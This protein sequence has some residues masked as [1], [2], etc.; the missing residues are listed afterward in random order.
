[1][2]SDIQYKKDEQYDGREVTDREKIMNIL[3]SN[4][5]KFIRNDGQIDRCVK[6]YAKKGMVSL[7]FEKDR[8]TF[9][10]LREKEAKQ[11]T[12]KEVSDMLSRIPAF[13]DRV[14]ERLVFSMRF[15]GANHRVVVEGLDECQKTVNYFKGKDSK[16][17]CTNIPCFERIIYR[18]LYPSI[19]L[20]CRFNDGSLKYDFI[21]NPGASLRDINIAYSGIEGLEIDGGGNL[22]IKTPMGH[23]TDGSPKCYQKIDGRQVDIGAEFKLGRRTNGE[24]T[25]GFSINKKYDPN[26]PVII[27]PEIIYSSF[28]GGSGTD[29]GR[30]IA[31]DQDGCVYITGA[32]NSVDFPVRNGFDP[33]FNINYDAFVTK[34]SRIPTIV[35]SSYLGGRGL[36]GGNSIDMGSDIAI[37]R[38]GNAYIVG[39]TGSDNFPIYN[40]FDTQ[41]GGPNDAFITKISP[42]PAIVYSSYLGGNGFEFGEGIAVDQNGNAYVTGSTTSTDFPRANAFQNNLSGLQDAFITKINPVPDIVYSSY[43]GGSGLDAGYSVAADDF[44]NTYITG[45]TTSDDF[46]RVNAFQNTWG[47][48]FDAFITKISSTPTIVYSSYLGGSGEDTGLSVAVDKMGNAYVAGI[49]F[50]P[51]FPTVNAFD[52]SISGP[53]D[54]FIAKISPAHSIVYS[55]YVGGN[56]GDDCLGVVVDRIGNAYITGSTNST[57]FPI[58][59]A[60]QRELA[61]DYDAYVMK[62]EAVGNRPECILTTKVFDSLK[63]R[64]CSTVF[65]PVPHNDRSE[66]I[67]MNMTFENGIIDKRTLKMASVPSSPDYKNV[68]FMFRVPCIS[69]YRDCYTG[70]IM[71]R[72][73]C[74]TDIWT[75]AVLYM[76]DKREELRFDI[77]IET[78]T[79]LL[80][81][82][83]K[84][85]GG[86]KV[87]IGVFYVI[88][89]IAPVQLEVISDG[90]CDALCSCHLPEKD[91]CREFLDPAVT[92]F[93]P[94]YPM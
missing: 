87:K 10:F 18:N 82:P 43:L 9:S 85:H 44:G 76:P 39:S 50:S 33:S 61:G 2:D 8:I 21:I 32:T 27:D 68:S 26:L 70:R 71:E 49:T 15:K 53:F 73:G 28:L 46:P 31:V 69:K 24:F 41:L 6:Y 77:I 74:L 57:D 65:I 12:K 79:K 11:K 16:K 4:A 75:E 34:I 30:K 66:Y 17:W 19:D 64:E 90:Y 81:K 84:I 80:D 14:C 22:I 54:G 52:N 93:P 40:G 7:F 36:D 38:N 59:N 48:D 55:S 91:K 67:L 94:L 5:F 92:E 51:N 62:I 72:A 83:Q 56:G 89:S 86:F 29:V 13:R 42:A 47:G 63:K 60:F 78:M 88:K 37:D 58:K 25:Y 23:F 3:E 35:Y 1:M 45:D 20:V